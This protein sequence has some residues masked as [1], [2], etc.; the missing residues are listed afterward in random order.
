MEFGNKLNVL[1]VLPE[2]AHHFKEHMISAI[3]HNLKAN[4]RFRLMYKPDIMHI[5]V[6]VIVHN[7]VVPLQAVV[8]YYRGQYI[9][10]HKIKKEI[11]EINQSIHNSQ[12]F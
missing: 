1:S 8:D 5:P 7:L 2:K 4:L 11:I 10:A 12:F 3:T 6:I 9:Y